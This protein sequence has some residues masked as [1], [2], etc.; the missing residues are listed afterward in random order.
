VKKLLAII[1]MI[2]LFGY[3]PS[4]KLI[5]PV[6]A[7]SD[8]DW[9]HKTFWQEPWGA[10]GVHMGIDIFGSSKQRVIAPSSCVVLLSTEIGSG[11]N[12][13]YCL[14]W[15]W[16]VHYFA[17]MSSVSTHLGAILRQ[18]DKIGMVGSTGNAMRKPTHLHYEIISLIPLPWR[19]DQSSYG[20]LKALHLNPS[21]E[22]LGK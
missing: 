11:G 14:G 16:R 17:H 9:N 21:D 15:K 13:V 3:L 8:R 2:V 19:V 1:G 18:G 4:A 20:W 22:L 6:D 7:A 12:S 5:I 10:S